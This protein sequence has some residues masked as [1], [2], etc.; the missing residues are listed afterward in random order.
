MLLVIHSNGLDNNG[1][2]CFNL[3]HSS[4]KGE[5]LHVFNDKAAEQEEE[6]TY[7]HIQ[8]LHAITEHI[9]PEENPFLKQ[10]I[11]AQPCVPSFK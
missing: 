7:A 8:C 11:Y 10:N 1:P 2:V 4:L 3:S 6:T 9:F 5:A